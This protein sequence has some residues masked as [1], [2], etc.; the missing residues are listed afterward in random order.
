MS[1]SELTA[2]LLFLQ[3]KLEKKDKRLKS[4]N[5][6]KKNLSQQLQEY[7]KFKEI[8]KLGFWKFTLP[9]FQI[10][11]SDELYNIFEIDKEKT[12]LTF[13]SFLEFIHPSDRTETK[14]ELEKALK[15]KTSIEITHRIITKKGKIKILHV[16]GRVF[17]NTKGKPY[18]ILGTT[19]D[20]TGIKKIETAKWESEEKFISL[21]NATPGAISITSIEKGDIIEVN[22]AFC[23]LAGYSRADLIGKSTTK[24]KIWANQTDRK[25]FVQMLKKNSRVENFEIQITT[26]KGTSRWIT[27]HADM[28]KYNNNLRILTTAFDITEKKE[29]ESEL[30][31]SNEKYRELFEL[32]KEAIFLIENKTGKIIE[33]NEAAAE[34]Y[35]Y[36][37]KE[38]L[39]MFNT[40]LSAEPDETKRVT[41]SAK[42]SI[43][44]PLRYHR[45]K[46]GTVFPVEIT[47]RFFNWKGKP[48][49]VAAM[50]DITD[51][52]KAE[53]KIQV[54]NRTLRTISEINQLIVRES[55]K[56]KMLSETCKILVEQ[57]KF[58]MAWVGMADYETHKIVPVAEYGFPKKYLDSLDIR[59]DKSPKGQGII[60]T[61][62]RTGKN[63]ISYDIENDKNFSK[64]WKEAKGLGC[65][66]SAAYPLKINK[67]IIGAINVHLLSGEDL[68]DDLI[69]LL[70]ELSGDISLSL[71][72]I[73]ESEAREK[74]EIKLRESERKYQVLAE[75][76]PV[77]I[78]QTDP[79]GK[80]TYVNPR[81]TEISGMSAKDAMGDGWLNA[82]NPDER[83]NILKGWKQVTSKQSTSSAE[84]SFVHP[85]GKISWVLGQAKPDI[86]E[87]GKIVGYIGTITDITERKLAE[88]S[89]HFAN[90]V[91][92]NSPVVLF[93]WEAKKG[94]PV[95]YV[96]QNV[97]QFGYSPE[98]LLS[99]ETPYSSLIYPDDLE[100]V[101]EEVKHYSVA[102]VYNFRQEYRIVKKDGTVCWTDDRTVIERDD[103]DKIIFYQGTVLDITIQKKAEEA[104]W[105]SRQMLQLVLDN[106]PQRIFWK[107]RN[108]NY[109]GC[110]QTFANDAGLKSPEEII[111][112]HDFELSWKD[113]A[114]LYR[115]DDTYVMENEIEKVN[116]EEPQVRTD[117]TSIWLR[118]SKVPLRNIEGKVIGILGNYDDITE[119]KKAEIAIWESRQML[120][121]VLD[122]IPQR[123]FW[124]DRK[125]NY[126]GCN[127]VFANDASLESPEE[128][129]GKT[130]FELFEKESAQLFRND[131]AYVVENEIEKLS[132]EEP[133][134]RLDGTTGWLRTSKVPLR[135]YDGEVI[136]VLGSYEDITEKKNAEQALLENEERLRLAL[137]SAN[138]GLYDLNI[139]TGNAIVSDEYA[140]MLGYDPKTFKETNAKW[141]ERLHPDDAEKIGKVYHD[142]IN[143]LIPEYRIEFRQRTKSNKWKWILSLG[144]IV[145]RDENGKPLRMLGTHTDIT[146]RK[147]AEK[148]LVQSEEKFRSVFVDSHDCIYIT[149]SDGKIIDM[150]K[151]GLNLFGLTKE[152][153]N[154]VNALD[155]Y[156]DVE[157][158]ERFLNELQNKDYVKDYSVKLVNKSGKI[159]DCLI[160]SSSR[161]DEH[162]N[163]VGYQG[164]IRDVTSQK[165]AERNLI[166]AKNEAEKADRMKTEFLAQMSH[167]IRTP[168]N[169]L[170][171]FSSLIREDIK[172]VINEQL[173]EYF[174]YQ[175]NAG[176]RIIR[177]I[178]LI[179]NMSEIQTGSF[180]TSFKRLNL[181]SILHDLFNEFKSIAFE[182]NLELKLNKQSDDYLVYADEYSVSQIFGNLINN[183]IKY[184][185]QGEIELN[186]FRDDNNAIVEIKDSGIGISDEYLQEIFEPFTQEE[187]GYTRRFEGS[188][189]GLALVK[190]YCDLNNLGISVDSVKGK[191]TSFSI[192]FELIEE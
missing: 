9:H 189:L 7:T 34:M 103:K 88:E 106:I 31:I 105:E 127:K 75:M 180:K 56:E 134:A 185:P 154:E 89:L 177:T 90:L 191:G 141:L 43:V 167:E 120:Q 148:A 97:K 46:N 80:T 147:N 69:D 81:W 85:D 174:T 60:G 86:N 41:K 29:K 157:D 186:V 76:S 170:L 78:F 45:K 50:R 146:E 140:T 52:L 159:I 115:A 155:L 18:E 55:N 93:R 26:A 102:G 71:K 178:D 53:Q 57:G 3:D 126:L 124:K 36:A 100:R 24:L 15:K 169:T 135:N 83:E 27:M 187:Q 104:L 99:G 11:W 125:S 136:G 128:I 114:H 10:E 25:K 72:L 51:R 39:K 65:R 58:P 131:D 111:G 64:W 59:F 110:N 166:R 98:E 35:G 101:A 162:G 74:A 22:E 129:V 17:F 48:V 63:V 123:I 108:F 77:G 67:K 91:V 130:D 14:K 30:Q 165:E 112:K 16:R 40:D 137:T 95:T 4:A 150:N 6:S 21:F 188:G 19:Q 92:E 179:L 138:Q 133:Q 94:W 163:I 149:S 158:R 184:T 13:D 168:I 79:N 119:Q 84:Y 33:A 5:K 132:F 107:D 44:I 38:L 192:S 118:T 109:L 161:K 183:A 182:R 160:S 47:G 172:D 54:L 61:A 42:G 49:H 37:H 122:N 142:Y 143:N 32:G 68:T 28:V 181:L 145:E 173:K 1:K 152:E 113:S 82:V 23:K 144:K 73:E 87:R 116:F 96:S 139:Q 121:L 70:D 62:V 153:I 175:L 117:G 176:K 164:V 151:P 190:K 20:V 156:K 8:S 66:A 171:S 2:E 12:K